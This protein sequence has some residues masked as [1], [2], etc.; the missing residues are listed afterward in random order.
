MALQT[1]I[2]EAKSIVASRGDGDHVSASKLQSH[3]EALGD[4]LEA[5]LAV[6]FPDEDPVVPDAK[7]LVETL[8]E[9]RFEVSYNTIQHRGI[10]D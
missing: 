8:V 5:V 2:A 1:A 10:Q 6:G 3:A 4:K 9:M 7:K